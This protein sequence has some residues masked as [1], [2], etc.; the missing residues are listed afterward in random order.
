[1][2]DLNTVDKDFETFVVKLNK[3]N[4]N[5]IF[6]FEYNSEK[7]WLKKARATSSNLFHKFCFKFFSYDILIPVE[8][9]L[10]EESVIFESSKLELFL[11]YSI[12]VPRTIFKNKDF[13]VMSDSGNA[14]YSY[15][16]K[17]DISSSEFYYYLDKTVDALCEIHNKG[18]YH[19]GAQTRN[20]TYKNGKVFAIDL[21]DSFDNNKADLKTLQFRDFF[22]LLLSMTKVDNFDFSYSHIIDKY[23]EQTKNNDFK[24]KLEDLY[25]SLDFLVKLNQNSL[26]HK[27]FPR[28]V[29]GFCKLL[30]EL[31]DY[32][33]Y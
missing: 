23:I 19:G 4:D 9:K 7:F 10:P 21:E 32:N 20:F 27:I 16:K 30:E 8:S 29:K 6:S 24:E 33:E 14:I 15:L 17:G 22:L 28:D 18:F 13:F 1:M 11:E 5:E 3:Q 12:N 25:S 2:I 26:F 31:R